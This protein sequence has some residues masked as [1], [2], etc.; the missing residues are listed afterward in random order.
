[1]K[2][3]YLYITRQIHPSSLLVTIAF[4]L[5]WS[6]FETGLTASI[7]GIILLPLLSAVIFVV[8]FSAVTL[9][10]RFG[11]Y[12]EW[13]AALSKGLVLGV[14]AAIP[15]SVIGLLGA[16]VL[17]LMRL[18]YGVDAD[19]ILLGKLTHSWRE[20]EVM[21]RKLAPADHKNRSIEEV[22]DYLYTQ[23]VLSRALKDHLHELRQQRNINTH[24]IS[25]QDL[26]TLVDDVQRMESMLRGRFLRS[27]SAS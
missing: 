11:S 24:Q 14:V 25:T 7:L 16:A 13:P 23:R 12:D 3:F 18:A 27:R 1:M 21:L 5:L 15:F 22:I 4:D 9:V 20:I 10:Q 8:C 6:V 26:A 2:D 19:V 17:G